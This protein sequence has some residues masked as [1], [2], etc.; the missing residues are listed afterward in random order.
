[1]PGPNLLIGN[2]E[3]LASTLPREGRG[4]GPKAY[5]YTIQ[6]ARNRLR[7]GIAGIADA[8]DQLPDAAKPR[9]EGTGLVTVH[10]A[11]L[12]KTQMP[13]GVFRRA[14]LRTLG[15]RPAIVTPEKDARVSA[16]SGPQPTAE[17]YVSGT[18]EAFRRLGTLLMS[19]STAKIH[20]EE[21]CRLEA[22]RFLDPADRLVRLEGQDARI[23]VEVVLHGDSSDVVLLDVFE[24]YANACGVQ[25]GR[26]KLLGVPGLIFMPGTASRSNLA[27]F[28]SFTA[29]RAVRR[30]PALRLNRPVIRQRLTVQAPA[31]PDADALDGSLRVVVFDGGLG[32]RDFSR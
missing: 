19:D 17:L 12:A 10:P 5:P 23:P 25:L 14:G 22:V 8:L 15:S 32:A 2:G 6:E 26:T 16:P 29:L 24:A 7:E 11:F 20:Q 3:V 21:F 1:M 13:A 31:L 4:N 30:L 27:R 9:G 18:S 28:A